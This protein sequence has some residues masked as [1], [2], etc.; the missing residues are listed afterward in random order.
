MRGMR[1]ALALLLLLPG[2][3]LAED[4]YQGAHDSFMAR[5]PF[6][7]QAG[8]RSQAYPAVEALIATK[9][10]RAIMDLAEEIPVSMKADEQV[11]KLVHAE[12]Q[13]GNEAVLAASAL[14]KHI[15]FLNDKLKAGGA[16]DGELAKKK[17]ERAAAERTFETVVKNVRDFEARLE[18][19]A[20]LRHKLAT[21]AVSL[22]KTL[23]G[24]AAVRILPRVRAAFD[25]RDR[26]QGLYM[27]QIIGA[28]PDPAAV[29][30][31]IAI[32]EEP[33]APRA[34]VRGAARALA[35]RKDP[36]GTKALIALWR[37]SAK[38]DPDPYGKQIRAA[39]SLAAGQQLA[40]PAAAEKW[41]VSLPPKGQ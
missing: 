12:Q 14:A 6:F 34:T 11:R 28:C 21:G 25:V 29:A 3:V 2:A 20:E 41:A 9:D 32:L 10:P 37:R 26:E 38:R 4:K 23:R 24:D 17:E 35:P 36:V 7:Y 22:S 19:I 15:G 13:L 30:Q 33:K 16:D 27:L 39:L 5:R 31:L 18:Y 40:D 1:H 8:A